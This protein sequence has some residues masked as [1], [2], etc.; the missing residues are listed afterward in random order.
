V[1]TP[2]ETQTLIGA[3]ATAL[4][5]RGASLDQ[6]YFAPERSFQINLKARF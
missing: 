6:Y 1:V 2:I 5:N 3:T 4:A